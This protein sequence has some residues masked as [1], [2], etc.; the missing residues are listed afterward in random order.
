MK[1]STVNVQFIQY[2]VEANTMEERDRE[3]FELL[4]KDPIAFD[5]LQH[6]AFLFDKFINGSAEPPKVCPAVL[7]SYLGLSDALIPLYPEAT[8]FCTFRELEEDR[9]RFVEQQTKWYKN[10][11]SILSNCYLLG[12]VEQRVASSIITTVPA[13]QNGP[14]GENNKG[15]Q[16][17]VTVCEI[18]EEVTQELVSKKVIHDVEQNELLVINLL[19][20]K[21]TLTGSNDMESKISLSSVDTCISQ[22]DSDRV[23]LQGSEEH[24]ETLL[25]VETNDKQAAELDSNDAVTIEISESAFHGAIESL[26]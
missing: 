12:R 25:I 6:V 7:A 23:T 21:P 5:I 15:E 8:A 11:A 9:E 22:N 16:N 18:L 4:K 26:V 3:I 19:G 14:S 20:E 10:L 13:N 1:Y 2:L 24:L 17:R